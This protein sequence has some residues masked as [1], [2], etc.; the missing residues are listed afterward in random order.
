MV[1]TGSVLDVIDNTGAKRIRCIKI[2]RI[3]ARCFGRPGESIV[4]SMLFGKNNKK[5]LRGRVYKAVLLYTRFRLTRKGGESLQFE[6]NAVV[7]LK[8]DKLPLGT[9]ILGSMLLELRFRGFMK[10]ISLA[11]AV[12]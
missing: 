1:F 11:L 6:N 2:L 3:G 12:F 10:I 5:V 4:A 9:R 7:I 8:V